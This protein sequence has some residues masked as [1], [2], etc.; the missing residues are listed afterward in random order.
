VA[1]D[2][3]TAAL[4]ALGA[5]EGLA[6]AAVLVVAGAGGTS[7]ADD[8]LEQISVRVAGAACDALATAQP[9]LEPGVKGS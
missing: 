6:T 1:Q 5:R 9:A 3:G 7:L 2:L 4:Y 8:A